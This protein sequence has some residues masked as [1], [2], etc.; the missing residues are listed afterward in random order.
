MLR[1]P[2]PRLS[3]GGFTLLELVGSLAALLVAIMGLAGVLVSVQRQR[4]QMDARDAV[5]RSVSSLLEEVR[6]T[7]P[8]AIVATFDGNTRFVYGIEGSFDAGAVIR[9]TV[10]STDPDLLQLAI[11]AAWAAGGS[12]S[13]FD[14]ETVVYVPTA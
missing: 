8:D 11:D 12:A 6:S 13:T 14:I 1:S 7:S 10:D 4:E 5:V 3:D 9:V 2:R